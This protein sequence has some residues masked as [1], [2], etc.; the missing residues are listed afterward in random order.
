MLEF[1]TCSAPKN[2]AW[3]AVCIVGV[4]IMVEIAS[5]AAWPGQETGLSVIFDEEQFLRQQ[6]IAHV[7]PPSLAYTPSLPSLT[8]MEPLYTL[9][10]GNED[11]STI[12]ARKNNIFIKSS[13]DDLVPIPRDSKV[14]LVN[15]ELECS[16][17]MDTPSSPRLDILGGENFDVDSHLGEHLVNLLMKDKEID[18]PRKMIRKLLNDSIPTKIDNGYY[19]LEGDILYLEN[20]FS[21]DPIPKESK[22]LISSLDPSCDSSFVAITDTLINTSSNLGLDLGVL[23]IVTPLPDSKHIILRDVERFDPYISLTQSVD[24]TWVM[25]RLFDRFPTCHYP[26]RWHTHLRW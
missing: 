2:L 21:E 13:V 15:T 17:P 16:M 1:S 26:V 14:T 8:T 11:I 23:K 20:L 9:L 12:L 7:T 25:E 6:S 19:N 3:L 5:V 24:M 18:L 4:L 10:T 22:N